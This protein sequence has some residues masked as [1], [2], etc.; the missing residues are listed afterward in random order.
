MFSL[1]TDQE[2]NSKPDCDRWTTTL[3]F[4]HIWWNKIAKCWWLISSSFA[5]A[6]R[7]LTLSSRYQSAL[8]ALWEL[9]KSL[10]SFWGASLCP[11]TQTLR[12]IP[13]LAKIICSSYGSSI[14]PEFTPAFKL[15]FPHIIFA[16]PAKFLQTV[17]YNCLL[18]N[19]CMHLF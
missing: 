2:N 6:S 17:M 5:E 3:C 12:V 1:R 16:K 9:Q 14:E 4:K 13:H 8:I 10:L 15:S 11:G 18:R 19:W 7:E